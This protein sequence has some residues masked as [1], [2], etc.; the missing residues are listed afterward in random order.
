[1]GTIGTIIGK[2]D[3]NISSM[4]LSRL[5]PRGKA[6]M[7]LALDQPL[8]EEHLQEIRALPGIHNAKAVRL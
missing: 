3:I 1:M 6:L 8:S 5:Q 2:A 7:T 4:H